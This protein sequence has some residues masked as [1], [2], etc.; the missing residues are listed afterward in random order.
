MGICGNDLAAVMQRL[1]S[2]AVATSQ[3]SS[4]RSLVHTVTQVNENV[5][6]QSTNQDQDQHQ[7]ITTTTTTTVLLNAHDDRPSWLEKRAPY[8]A[9]KM[10][11]M[12]SLFMPL[13][14]IVGPPGTGKTDTVGWS[15]F[16]LC[17]NICRLQHQQIIV[18]AHSNKALDQMV[19]RL[20]ALY[21]H[22][23]ENDEH[24]DD[25]EYEND[26]D[27]KRKKEKFT[28]LIVRLGHDDSIDATVK[29]QC[30]MKAIISRMEEKNKGLLGSRYG[31]YHH[32]RV[33]KQRADLLRNAN[34]IAMTVSGA[35][36]RRF[37]FRGHSVGAMICE[38]AAK[39]TQPEAVAILSYNPKRVIMVG[40]PLQLAPVIRH[41]EVC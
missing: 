37:S 38:E 31:S 24:D 15:L 23:H 22:E 32:Q 18:T 20:M 13:T 27:E 7:K 26:D 10:A 5:M 16:I 28:P 39:I 8:P 3:D 6:I 29:E 36:L 35:C 19:L 2:S 9:Q 11:I 40:D 30:S 34:V 41:I 21:E 4:Q 17:E 1:L 14:L 33:A 12:S 25:D